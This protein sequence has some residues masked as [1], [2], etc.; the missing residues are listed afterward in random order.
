M[1]GQKVEW[2]SVPHVE[3]P[4]FGKVDSKSPTISMPAYAML[5]QHSAIINASTVIL[6]YVLYYTFSHLRGARVN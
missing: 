2:P 1:I 5:N 6:L 3:A 4:L